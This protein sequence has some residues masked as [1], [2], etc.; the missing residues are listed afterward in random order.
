MNLF[1]A[2]EKEKSKLENRDEEVAGWE[3][4]G[5][6]RSDIKSRKNSTP[7]KLPDSI[8]EPHILMTWTFLI[9]YLWWCDAIADVEDGKEDEW[10]YQIMSEEKEDRNN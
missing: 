2:S 4:E 5:E 1:L 9:S 8:R 6:K 3:G 7:L 10:D